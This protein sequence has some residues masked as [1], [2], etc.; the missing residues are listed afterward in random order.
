VTALRSAGENLKD[1]I[2]TDPAKLA[3]YGETIVKESARL[4]DMIAQVLEFAGMRARR[5]RNGSEPVDLSSVI[6]EAVA[7]SRWVIDGDSVSVTTD[8]ESNLPRPRGDARA[9]TRAVQNLVANA[10]RHGGSG[11]WVAVRAYREGNK[12][13]VTVEDR[14]PGIDSRDAAH[15]FEPF[16]RGRGTS[17]VRGSGLGLT[18]VQQV[19]AAHGGTI[20]VQR[21]RREGAAFT[22]TLPLS[23]P[24]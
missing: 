9:L 22:I 4:G 18:I 23:N 5:E 17:A 24:A 6:K 21:R 7:Q 11:G 3:R 16:Y 19:V 2:I 12:V 20:E 15:L 10:I 1:G 14:G 13:A 8:I